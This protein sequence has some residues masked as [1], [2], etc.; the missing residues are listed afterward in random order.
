[1]DRIKKDFTTLT[2]V[3]I[4]VA[5]AINV[6]VG[7]LVILLKLPLYLDSI[8]TILVGLL[9]G[10]WAG[11]VTGIISNLIWSITGLFPQ[12]WAWAHVA[13][14]VGL[15]AGFFGRFIKRNYA[16]WLVGG[17]LT[18]AVAAVLSA[19]VSAA[20][21]GG[22]TGTGQDFL[23]GLFRATGAS[24]VEATLGQ[25]IVS[26]PLDKLIS[27][28]LVFLVVLGLPKRFLLRFPRSENVV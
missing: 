17:L 18:G 21:F 11:A 3:M 19:P 27:F 9:A 5:V 23:V 15:L 26:D 14:V 13:A 4:P 8:G 10:P 2:L 7:Q 25:G 1:M 20:L 22:V 28:L 12:A 16:W 6:A 24:I